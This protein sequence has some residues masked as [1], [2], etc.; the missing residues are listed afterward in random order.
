MHATT[1]LAVRHQG[2]VVL[3]SDGQVTLGQTVVKHQARKVRRLYHDHVLAGFAGTA[4]DGFALFARFESKLEEHRVRDRAEF[5]EVTPGEEISTGPFTMRFHRVAHSIPDGCAIAI[6]LPLDRIVAIGH[7]AGGHLALWAAATVDVVT[8]V[9]SLAG[10]TDL[11][12]AH[13][14]GLSSDATG[15]FMGGTP[16]DHDTDL[17]RLREP[18]T[19]GS[20]ATLTSTQSCVP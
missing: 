2:K 12:D 8:G 7:S 4:A 19:A 18:A 15:S 17:G 6:D 1:V 10:V 13:R 5:H 3:A 16:D 9:V 20:G 14:R 11:V